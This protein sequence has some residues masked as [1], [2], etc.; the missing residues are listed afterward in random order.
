ML[1]RIL[2]RKIT[3]AAVGINFPRT[4]FVLANFSPSQTFE[5]WNKFLHKLSAPR[6]LVCVTRNKFSLREK[7][8][9]L[10]TSTHELSSTENFQSAEK[11]STSQT[12]FHDSE[13]IHFRATHKLF[14]AKNVRCRKLVTQ[15]LSR[16]RVHFRGSIKK[17]KVLFGKV[18]EER[19]EL[20][21]AGKNI[22]VAGGCGS[23]TLGRRNG[24]SWRRSSSRSALR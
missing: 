11:S 15:K 4:N 12:R 20:P 24:V 21:T 3:F 9:A 10:Q 22:E 2:L 8:S 17:V 7:S 14:S 5:I 16:T 18:Y 23:E 6:T 1:S 19:R 13:Q